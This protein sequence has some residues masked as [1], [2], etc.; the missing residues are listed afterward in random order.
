MK[1]TDE[2]RGTIILSATLGSWHPISL[3]IDCRGYHRPIINPTMEDILR[4]AAVVGFALLFPTFFT[5]K[6][7]TLDDEEH[8]LN[9]LAENQE[10]L[11][12]VDLL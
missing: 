3:E 10:R 8:N 6:F 4:L 5:G 9:K 12:K 7:K 2:Q 1:T 11:I